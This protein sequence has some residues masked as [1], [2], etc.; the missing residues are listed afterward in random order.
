[1]KTRRN[2]LQSI[3]AFLSIG[4]ISNTV[5]AQ[6]KTSILDA[7]DQWPN[8]KNPPVSLYGGR[9]LIVTPNSAG[10]ISL[11]DRE[12]Q[13]AFGIICCENNGTTTVLKT[14]NNNIYKDFKEAEEDF[15][16]NP[17]RPTV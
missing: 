16:I 9:I 10:C 7:A 4:A 17:N 14:R 6:E 13:L 12:K 3:P 8:R 1:M 11:W 2:I 5:N 15:R